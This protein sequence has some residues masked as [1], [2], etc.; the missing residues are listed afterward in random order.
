MAGPGLI[1][2][3]RLR[4][5]VTIRRRVLQNDGHGG[6]QH[7]VQ[8]VAVLP[9]EVEGLDGREALL[10]HALQGIGAYRITIRYRTGLLTSDQAVLDDGTELNIT[11]I[12]DPDGRRIQLQILAN[13]GS[14]MADQ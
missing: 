6:Q 4:H 10:A 7:V 8:T 12:S 13:T 2:A 3:G 11:S 9:A 1:R 5:R 14:V